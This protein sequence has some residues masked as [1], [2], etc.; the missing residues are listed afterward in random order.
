MRRDDRD[1][2]DRETLVTVRVDPTPVTGEPRTPPKQ[3]GIKPSMRTLQ[4][5]GKS[6]TPGKYPALSASAPR[7]KLPSQRSLGASNSGGRSIS[8]SPS[9]SRRGSAAFPKWWCVHDRV[10]RDVVAIIDAAHAQRVLFLAILTALF[11]TD[12]AAFVSAPDSADLPIGVVMCACLLVIA[13]E[14]VANTLCRDG[15]AWS[16]FFWMDLAGTLAIVADVAWLSDGWL[17]DGSFMGMGATLRAARAAKYGSRAGKDLAAAIQFART[18]RTLSLVRHTNSS[19]KDG[20]TAAG[21]KNGGKEEKGGEKGSDPMSSSRMARELRDAV[22]KNVAVIVILTVFAA[23]LLAWNDSDTIPAAYH[24]SITAV[25]NVTVGD[26]RFTDSGE[27]LFS[28]VWAIRLT[29]CFV[30]SRERLL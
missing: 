15:Y 4:S 18:F 7:P 11:L 6:L 14:F 16:F 9:R 2:D 29:A 28:F 20:K 8:Q 21:G 12:V 3:V 19:S 24:D 17:P 27:F 22:S 23:P 1:D 25:A 30:Y 13:A 10:R 5:A 26:E